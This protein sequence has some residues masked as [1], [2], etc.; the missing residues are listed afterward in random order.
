MILRR[1][2]RCTARSGGIAIDSIHLRLLVTTMF[3]SHKY[4]CIFIHVQK[5]GGASITE[6]FAKRDPCL[7]QPF[8]RHIRIRELWPYLVANNVTNYYKFALVRNPWDRL[9]SWYEF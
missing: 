4:R 2:E 7:E 9:V 6:A 1:C 5:T 8:F 3:I